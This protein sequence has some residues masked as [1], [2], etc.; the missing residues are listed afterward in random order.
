MLHTPKNKGVKKFFLLII[1]TLIGLFIALFLWKFVTSLWTLKY[2][3]DKAKQEL[4]ERINPAFT[5]SPDVTAQRRATASTIEA[6]KLI[7]SFNPTFG[8]A[9]APVKIIAFIDFECPYCQKSYPF[10]KQ[11]MEEHSDV[12]QVIFK[13]FPI[14]SIHQDALGAGLASACAHEQGKFWEYHDML[15]T[16]KV[17]DVNSLVTYADTTGL[18]PEKFRNCLDSEKYLGAIQQDMEDGA[19]VGVR[20]TPTFIVNNKKVEGVLETQLWER[21]IINA[22]QKK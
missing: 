3:S 11:L 14:G 13:H 1:L 5:V 17:L 6:Q 21:V 8:S 22:L 15:F 10:F 18:D 12:V 7:R 2:G 4:S 16:Q 20:G 9:Q 19:A